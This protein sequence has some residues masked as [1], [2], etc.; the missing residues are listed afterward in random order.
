MEAAEAAFTTASEVAKAVGLAA[1]EA[2]RIVASV[3]YDPGGG[4]SPNCRT[5]RDAQVTAPTD[6]HLN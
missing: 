2:L 3:V 6:N 4:W 5:L 1:D